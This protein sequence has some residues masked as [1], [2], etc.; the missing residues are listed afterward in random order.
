MD[1]IEL[2]GRKYISARKAAKQY[3]YTADYIGQLI[4]SGKLLGRKIGKGWFVEG[5]SLEAYMGGAPV[6]A[7]RTE[8][9]EE[10]AAAPG[11]FSAEAAVSIP[12]SVDTDKREFSVSARVQRPAAPLLQYFPDHEPAFPSVAKNPAIERQ[13]ASRPAEEES[14]FEETQATQPSGLSYV[15]AFGGILT[16]VVF[17]G[18]LAFAELKVAYNAETGTASSYIALDRDELFRR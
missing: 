13:G 4:R 2:E 6:S 7:F 12:V 11:A 8:T 10:A 1:E 17:L 5:V 18:F 14:I 9:S 16:A 3:G 15:T